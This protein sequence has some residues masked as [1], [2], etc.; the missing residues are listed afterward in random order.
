[1]QIPERYPNQ[2]KASYFREAKMTK[3]NFQQL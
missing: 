1:M 3:I 2:V